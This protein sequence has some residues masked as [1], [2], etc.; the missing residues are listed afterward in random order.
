MA[1]A[2]LLSS[3]RAE[4]PEWGVSE[5]ARLRAKVQTALSA[6]VAGKDLNSIKIEGMPR[7]LARW[8]L[9]HNSVGAAV[10]Q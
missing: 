1:A 8:L 9:E 2:R 5:R 6:A 10:G 7:Q 4:A 3:S